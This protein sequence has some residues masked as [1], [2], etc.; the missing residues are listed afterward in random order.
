MQRACACAA[1]TVVFVIP[2]GYSAY[3]SKAVDAVQGIITNFASTAGNALG[4]LWNIV[5]G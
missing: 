4:G 5:I 2:Q 3:N 1:P